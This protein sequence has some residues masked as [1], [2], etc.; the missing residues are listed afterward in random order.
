MEKHTMGTR[1]QGSLPSEMPKIEQ[2]CSLNKETDAKD[3]LASKNRGDH[4][5]W[6]WLAS[7]DCMEGSFALSDSVQGSFPTLGL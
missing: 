3:S 1:Q 5:S 6:S 4:L 7:N 2:R